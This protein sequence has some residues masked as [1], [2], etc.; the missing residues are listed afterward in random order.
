MR[1][2][3]AQGIEP[4]HFT[5]VIKDKVF[6][7]AAV[8]F[9]M[10]QLGGSDACLAMATDYA[11]GRYAFGRPIASFQALKHRMA[12]LYADRELAR[13]NCYWAA[14]A[15]ENDDAELREAATSAKISASDALDHCTV[16]MVQMHGGVG[17]TWEYDCH[18]FYRRGKI[19]AH[20]LG[21]TDE[22][23][24]RL[25]TQLIEDAA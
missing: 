2:K 11:K 8:L 5:W 3:W 4:R 13:S 1:G 15:L 18:L 17:Y 9:S 16:E 22:W 24:E 23:R 7:R 25:I 10:E 21:S 20:Q 6:D 14:W 19:L 12:D